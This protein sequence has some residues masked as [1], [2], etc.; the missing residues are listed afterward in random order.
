MNTSRT[1]ILD[2][3]CFDIEAIL[4][5][6]IRGLESEE[7]DETI[8]LDVPESEERYETEVY[9]NLTKDEK[10]LCGEILESNYNSLL[11]KIRLEKR[12][13]DG[14][15]DLLF[16]ASKT[17]KDYHDSHFS[18]FWAIRTKTDH[19]F[20]EIKASFWK[21]HIPLYDNEDFCVDDLIGL[22][23]TEIINRG[24]SILQGKS[25]LEQI[26]FLEWI[27]KKLEEYSKKNGV[28]DYLSF[29]GGLRIIERNSNELF[30]WIEDSIL[31]ATPPI[32]FLSRAQVQM[33]RKEIEMIGWYSNLFP[34]WFLIDRFD[35]LVLI[36]SSCLS[37]IDFKP[38]RAK[39]GIKKN[40]QP[41]VIV[42][43]L[44]HGIQG[45]NSKYQR[46]NNLRDL[47]VW[48]STLFYNV[49]GFS[50]DSVRKALERNKHKYK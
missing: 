5:R 31:I 39:E 43:Y 18:I 1:K 34:H 4:I 6:N 49:Q 41:A 17:D 13:W 14:I 2:Q 33:L 42:R 12:G 50:Y 45:F 23:N 10:K 47:K 30:R 15:G 7:F 40:C 27:K 11:K 16:D 9:P 3:W 44:I 22:P 20:Q 21:I 36:K 29:D 24:K 48:I 32:E 26:K 28:L 37:E 25:I 46:G 19:L 8:L 38:F 35:H